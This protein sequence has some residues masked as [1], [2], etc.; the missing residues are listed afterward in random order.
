MFISL[1]QFFYA[2]I[3]VFLTLK[4]LPIF[5]KKQHKADFRLLAGLFLFSSPLTRLINIQIL[6]HLTK[7][8]Y[9]FGLFY[10]VAYQLVYQ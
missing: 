1:S 7:V 3:W 4:P 5:V 8:F 2:A 6:E 9:T 10:P